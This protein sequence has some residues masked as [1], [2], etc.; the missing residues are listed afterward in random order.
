MAVLKPIEQTDFVT[1][2]S[3]LLDNEEFSEF[4]KFMLKFDNIQDDSL[5]HDVQEIKTRLGL[6]ANS[7]GARENLFRLEGGR[8]KALPIYTKNAKRSVRLYCIRYSENLLILG[9]GGVKST[10]TYEEDANLYAYV[11]CLKNIDQLI[12]TETKRL[13]VRFA[14][15]KGM[16]HIID[17]LKFNNNATQ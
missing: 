12:R 6:I 8:I 14:D 17:N 10:R 5:I 16:C 3:P 2:Y 4:E 7:F 13:K 15:L 1:I 11:K 9:N